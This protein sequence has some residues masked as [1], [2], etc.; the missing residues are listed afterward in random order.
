MIYRAVYELGHGL[1]PSKT[2]QYDTGTWTE[3]QHMIF[4]NYIS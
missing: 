3:S 1:S 4:Q 2:S